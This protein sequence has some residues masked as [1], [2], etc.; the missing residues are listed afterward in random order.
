MKTLKI[1]VEDSLIEDIKEL[2]P[3]STDPVEALAN[4]ALNEWFRCL[5][6]AN[7]P[8]KYRNKIF[9]DL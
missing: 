5:K 8:Q 1:E 3:K 9:N 2:F 6:V 7:G 4:L